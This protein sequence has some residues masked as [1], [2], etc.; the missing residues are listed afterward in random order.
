[1]SKPART[2]I[3]ILLILFSFTIL[4]SQAETA[5]NQDTVQPIAS[6]SQPNEMFYRDTNSVGHLNQIHE[7]KGWT[8]PTIAVA[9][10]ITTFTS[11]SNSPP[12]PSDNTASTS[13]STWDVSNSAFGDNNNSNCASAILNGV[14]LCEVYRTSHWIWFADLATFKQNQVYITPLLNW[15]EVSNNQISQWLGFTLPPGNFDGG[16]HAVFVDP[17][18]G[19]IGWTSGGNIGIGCEAFRDVPDWVT[20]VIPHE[21]ANIFT[22]TITAGW[23]LDWW[24]DGRSPFPAMVAVKVEQANGIPYWSQQDA[25]DSGD[26]QYVMFR[27]ALQVKFGW[28]LFQT[29]F[30]TMKSDHVNLANIHSEYESPN[31]MALHY[32]KS[33]TVAYYLSRAAG[34]D[35]SDI[36]NQGTVGTQPP[37]WSGGAFGSYKINLRSAGFQVSPQPTKSSISSTS[38]SSTSSTIVSSTTSATVSSSSSSNS[39][40]LKASSRISVTVY[41]AQIARN[42][43]V[44]FKVLLQSPFYFNGRQPPI[45]S[46]RVVFTAWDTGTSCT[47]DS[48]GVCQITL[49]APATP[50]TYTVT[51]Q[52]AGDSTYASSSTTAMVKVV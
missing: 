37:A 27:D 14:T 21:I 22:S 7:V 41:A 45:A 9:P 17:R 44:S 38:V 8:G 11:L 25:W 3:T 50:G 34:T 28:Q 43:Q 35:L 42:G 36:L 1:M 16:R 29:A 6:S 40:P 13:P 15:P 39:D 10:S 18:P 26:P 12:A 23:P 48:N 20:A 30:A 46:R 4:Q 5:P 31:W 33:H 52:F 47:T 24:A 19:Y 51:V 2:W 32:V 49:T